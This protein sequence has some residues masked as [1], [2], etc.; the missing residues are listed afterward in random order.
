MLKKIFESMDEDRNSFFKTLYQET[1]F[2]G[3]KEFSMPENM[4][5]NLKRYI[6]ENKLGYK[7]I[8]VATQVN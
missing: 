3:E 4:R 5:K 6:L 8:S 7:L 1:N 2:T